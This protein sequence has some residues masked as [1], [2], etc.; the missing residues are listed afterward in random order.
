MHTHTM[1]HLAATC[2]LSLSLTTPALAD[3]WRSQWRALLPYVSVPETAVEA[4]DR[5]WTHLAESAGGVIACSH[6]MFLLKG[7]DTQSLSGAAANDMRFA[8]GRAFESCTDTMRRYIDISALNQTLLTLASRELMAEV[9]KARQ[10]ESV[11]LSVA[12]A[13]RIFARS[14]RR[15]LHVQRWAEIHESFMK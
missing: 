5:L 12:D 4:E 15:G 9:R 1:R 11:S 8:M 10:G 13:E 7:I 6:A 14:I 3:D 2:L